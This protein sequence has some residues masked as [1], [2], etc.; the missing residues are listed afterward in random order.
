MTGLAMQTVLYL[1]L[2]LFCFCLAAHIVIWRVFRPRK[3]IVLLTLIFTFGPSLMLGIVV[4]ASRIDL[5]SCGLALLLHLALAAV[6]INLYTLVAGFSPSIGIL[7]RVDE[8]M[9]RGLQRNELAPP[10][11]NDENLSGARRENLLSSGLVYESGGLLL[12]SPRGLLVSRIFLTFR[13]F[14]GLPD[15]AKG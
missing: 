8:S 1:G 13:R 7:E 11:F 9:P 4:L 3:Q 2:E 15:V 5:S 6:Y 10:W 14:L 12:L